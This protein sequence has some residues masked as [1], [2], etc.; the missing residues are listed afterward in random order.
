MIDHNGCPRGVALPIAQP[1]IANT[2][3]S[4]NSPI[5]GI[6]ILGPPEVVIAF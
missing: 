4:I 1:M 2:I 3:P 5:Y 6:T